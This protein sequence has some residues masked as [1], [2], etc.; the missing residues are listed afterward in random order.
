MGPKKNVTDSSDNIEQSVSSITTSWLEQIGNG[1]QEAWKRLERAYRRLVCWWCGK[2]G[3]PAQDI[4]DIV[5]EVFAAV[6]TGLANFEHKS[7]RGYLWTI[8]RNKVQ[9]YWRRNNKQPQAAGGSSIQEILASVEAESDQSIGSVAVATKIIFDAVVEMVK[10]EFSDG[11]WQAFWQCTV[12]ETPVA[13]VAESLAI[14]RN[15]V[16]L[17]KSRILRRIR[18]EFGDNWA[19][20]QK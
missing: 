17:A 2:S 13:E 7:F 4:D 14:T 11:D 9:D 1:D 18:E 16:Y 5:Q 6:V 20:V 10:G 15:Q 19:E 8:T 3:V 12:E